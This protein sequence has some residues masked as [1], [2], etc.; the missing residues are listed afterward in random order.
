M[1]SY[2]LEHLD[3]TLFDLY[4][5]KTWARSRKQEGLLPEVMVS[6][7]CQEIMGSDVHS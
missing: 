2:R 5:N 3:I 6:S 4:L 1:R 7:H